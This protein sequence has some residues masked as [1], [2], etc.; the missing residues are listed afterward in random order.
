MT[1]HN[2]DIYESESQELRTRRTPRSYRKKILR[3]GD[4]DVINDVC[5]RAMRPNRSVPGDP[6]DES[7]FGTAKKAHGRSWCVGV[8]EYW[9][10]SREDGCERK[11]KG[12]LSSEIPFSFMVFSRSI[13]V[14]CRKARGVEAETARGPI[15]SRFPLSR[16]ERSRC[17]QISRKYSSWSV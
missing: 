11:G 16:K 7:W 4:V 5:D 13:G 15:S 6:I 9:N 1:E 2:V 10:V 14:F 8:E 12:V 3:A 17:V